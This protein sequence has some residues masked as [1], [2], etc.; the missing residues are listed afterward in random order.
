MTRLT[1]I[2]ALFATTLTAQNVVVEENV[3]APMR[4]SVKLATDVYRTQVTE[5]ILSF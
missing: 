2:S 1:F 5:S 4:D 3:M